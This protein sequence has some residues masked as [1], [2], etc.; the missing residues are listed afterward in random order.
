MEPV[1][2]AT[3]GVTL[4]NESISTQGFFGILLVLI[5][6]FIVGRPSKN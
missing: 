3:L 4:L 6:I 2:A 5:G 1:T